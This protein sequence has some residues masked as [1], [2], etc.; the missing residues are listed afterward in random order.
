MCKQEPR[1]NVLWCNCLRRCSL[2][3]HDFQRVSGQR[4][5]PGRG[6]RRHSGVRQGAVS[7]MNLTVSLQ[8]GE[9]LKKKLHKRNFTGQISCCL[10]R[11]ALCFLT[12]V[13]RYTETDV[14]PC[15]G[16]SSKD[17]AVKCVSHP[18]GSHS[19][20]CESYH[21]ICSLSFIRGDI[22]HFFVIFLSAAAAAARC[23]TP[24]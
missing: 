13:L 7:F 3:E 8:R 4:R 6:W 17:T 16:E 18:M 23:L 15:S 21:I 22:L 2:G 19:V 14:I 11:V 10:P 12:F 9:T 5:R 20:R 24:E 1:Q